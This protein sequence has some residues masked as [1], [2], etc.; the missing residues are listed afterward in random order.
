M[1]QPQLAFCR[2]DFDFDIAYDKVFWFL[3][4]TNVNLQVNGS[5][6]CYWIINQLS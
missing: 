5:N 6:L 3:N 4:I 2:E 1:I